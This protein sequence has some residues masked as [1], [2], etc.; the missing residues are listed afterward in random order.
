MADFPTGTVTFLLTDIE[1]STA[2]WAR[3]PDAMA[4]ALERHD[5]LLTGCIE[6]HTGTVIRSRGEGDSFFAVFAQPADALAAAVA[7][8]QA[9]AAE[10]W[11]TTTPI[12]VRIGIHSGEAQLRDGDYFGL[13]VNRCA[14]LRSSAFGG[15]ILVSEITAGLVQD[16]YPQDVAPRDDGQCWLQ[17]LGQRWLR[18]LP[19]PERVFQ[20][21]HPDLLADLS[22]ARYSMQPFSPL[23]IPVTRLIGRARER[24]VARLILLRDDVRLLTLTGPGGVGKTRLSL[25]IAEELRDSFA[26]GICHVSLAPIEDRDLVASTI[27]QALGV[28][29][30]PDRPLPDAIAHALA[31]RQLLLLLDNFERVASAALLIADLLTH[32]PRLKILVTSRVV[33]HVQ[34]EHVLAVPPLPLPRG[35]AATDPSQLASSEAV[36]LFVDRA[37]AARADFTADDATLHDV[38]ELCRRLDGLPLAIELAAASVRLLTPRMMLTRFQRPLSLPSSRELNVPSRHRT[39]RAAIDWSVGL[40]EDTEQVLFRR[41]AQFVGGAAID[42]VAAV[43]TADDPALNLDDGLL[44][45]LEKS[46]VWI[47]P[48]PDGE[49]RFRMLEVLREYGLEQLDESGEAETIRRRHAELYV[50]VAEQAEPALLGPEQAAWLERLSLDLDNLRAA[51]SWFNESDETDAGLRLA[52]SIWRFWAMRGYPRE[53][54]QWLEGLLAK[55]PRDAVVRIRALNAAGYLAFLQGGYDLAEARHHEALELARAADDGRGVRT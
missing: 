40:L 19:R 11:P 44:S 16:A 4:H 21:V 33:L 55:A 41:L 23:P 15:Q 8:Q 1:G 5:A 30:A 48:A 22:S 39:L 3:E 31:E 34:G 36:Q 18:D 28:R 43:C 7:I 51:L 9:L 12:R 53:G 13:H 37:E 54:C 42:A 52:G 27:A 47:E 20:L 46:M 32:C 25:Q 50:A 2:L 14:R 35:D 26:D 38:A 29:E 24:D 10:P 49:P 45:L 6:A 17:D